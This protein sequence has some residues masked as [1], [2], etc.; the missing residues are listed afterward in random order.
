MVGPRPCPFTVP[1]IPSRKLTAQGVYLEELTVDCHE[2]RNE[3]RL[4]STSHTATPTN[5]NQRVH[6]K[7]H[8]HTKDTFAGLVAHTHTKMT[9][10]IKFEGLP[11]IVEI[12]YHCRALDG[13]VELVLRDW[14]TQVASRIDFHKHRLLKKSSA[15]WQA[16]GLHLAGCGAA[17]RFRKPQEVRQTVSG[18]GFGM[19]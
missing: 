19:V 15:S 16:K 7:I 8:Q 6:D 2:P 5:T 13:N 4:L 17:L 9:T 12:G 18:I 11:F 10:T 3:Q 1:G 14:N